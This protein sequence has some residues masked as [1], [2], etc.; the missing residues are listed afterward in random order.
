MSC[1]I[2]IKTKEIINLS[3]FSFTT[4]GYNIIS[5]NPIVEKGIVYSVFPEPTIDNKIP[6]GIGL[7]SFSTDVT[8]S[9]STLYYVR[10]YAM[11]SLGN[12]GYGNTLTIKT[13]DAITSECE[14]SVILKPGQIYNLPAGYKFLR[15]SDPY[16]L[17]STCI[18]DFGNAS[19]LVCYSFEFPIQDEVICTDA[20]DIRII[21][22]ELDDTII[23]LNPNYNFGGTGGSNGT[24]VEA[25]CGVEYGFPAPTNGVIYT[26]RLARNIWDQL[27]LN[28]SNV[29]V[30]VKS[31]MI[32]PD[33]AV[34]GIILRLP[35]NFQ[36]VRIKYRD[37]N[38]YNVD[39]GF[40]TFY[41]DG[42]LRDDCCEEFGGDSYTVGEFN[43]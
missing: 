35:N 13:Y 31:L 29:I 24:A 34:A 33:N 10:A 18:E 14:M 26:E 6:I 36:K 25:E 3:S 42:T 2:S 9:P 43:C 22:I 40:M 7:S 37:N 41:S 4:G 17:D 28:S 16:N 5:V 30:G 8:G 1:S 12:I 38:S 27:V 20:T 23:T 32:I 19:E 15:A 21:A 39:F 11:D